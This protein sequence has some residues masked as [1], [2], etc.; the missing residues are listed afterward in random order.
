MSQTNQ[1]KKLLTAKRAQQMSA[2]LNHFY[3][4]P[5]AKVSLELFLTIGLIL[6][7]G[8]FAIRPTLLTMSDLLKEIESK[9]ELQ[10]ALTKK[11][12]ALQTAQNEYASIEDR[13]PILN[14]AIPEQPDIIYTTK[15]LEKIAAD[16]SVIINNLS[17]SKL[18]EKQDEA[19]PFSQKTKE[20]L[21]ISTNISGDY[22]SI[23][24]FAEALRSSRKSFVI[25]S[26]TF[27]LQEDK[28]NKKLSANFTINTPYFGVK[29]PEDTTKRK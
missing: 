21:Q 22:I 24:N 26:V 15:I 17:I 23:K 3:T 19:I 8:M 12:A 5:V 27:S 10:T 14:A 18:P 13:L 2:A 28:G 9:K 6:F 20:T 4:N 11:V 1:S 25:E 29:I 7:L 16:N